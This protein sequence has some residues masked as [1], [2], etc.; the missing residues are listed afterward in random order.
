[1]STVTD[2][3][4]KHRRKPASRRRGKA[5]GRPLA[6]K[7]RSKTTADDEVPTSTTPWYRTTFAIAS[8]GGFL[9]WMA[10]PPL[11]IWPL[12]WVAPIP[13]LCL[14]RIRQMP[15]RR[16]YLAIYLVGFLHWLILLQ[17]VRLA[18][19]AT[20]FGWLGLGIYLGVYLPVF[21][22]LARIAVHRMKIPLVVAAP[23]IWTGLEYARGYMLT[24]FSMALL[25]H[26]QVGWLTLIQISDFAGAYA[27][28][29]VVMFVASCLARMILLPL[30]KEG[31]VWWPLP[32]AV[33]VLAATLVYGAWRIHAG[34]ADTATDETV[35]VALIQESI[36][37]KFGP[38]AAS[39]QETYDRYLELSQT[40]IQ[41]HQ[42]LDLII[43]PETVFGMPIPSF[44]ENLTV[45][46]ES[47]WTQAEFD[48]WRKKVATA[49][50][51]EVWVTVGRHL[52]V[53]TIIGTEGLHFGRDRRSTFNTAVS[54]GRD[55]LVK[56]RYNKMHPVCFGEYV[57]LG[58]TFPWLYRLTPMSGGLTSG[59]DPQAFEIAGLRWCPCI[60]FENTVP[61]LVRRQIVQLAREG[62]RPDVLVTL[63]ND[64]WFWGSSVLDLHLV[65]GVFR[66]VEHRTPMLIAANTGFSAW[67]DGNGCVRAK[68]PRHKP[69]IV[70]AE[71]QA[72]PRESPYTRWGDW[73]AAFCLLF[74]L[75]IAA[76][77][78]FG[79]VR[80]RFRR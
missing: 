36:D 71:I 45:P 74:C 26:T 68:G 41:D 37:T 73:P 51:Q 13:W 19:W 49:F 22:V 23:V 46:P 55:G 47:G 70:L 63:T 72:D 48:D 5:P 79:R 9:L 29:F 4:D 65:C 38:D 20:H 76:Q 16:P 25:G 12:A 69:E 61:H 67:I 14:V 52:Q 8:L 11:N 24:G 35:R 21:M 27:V 60:C 32:V 54:V 33:S 43:W 64:G 39:P 34:P 53:P 77:P 6:A 62:A 18:H 2:S 56:D 3:Q 30:R 17:G 50:R 44:D 78:V 58:E 31:V 42:N 66:A 15:G 10:F 28:T 40:A 80:N 7:T 59:E 57:P 1:M 75:A